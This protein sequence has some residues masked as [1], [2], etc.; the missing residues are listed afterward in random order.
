MHGE[1]TSQGV[2]GNA[3]LYRGVLL[4]TTSEGTPVTARTRGRVRIEDGHK[5]VRVYLGGELVANTKKVKLVW[6]KPYYP[7][8]LLPDR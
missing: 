3:R 1:V 2:E 8:V 4:D 5:H 6:E 7:H